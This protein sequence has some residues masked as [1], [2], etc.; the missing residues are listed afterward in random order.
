MVRFLNVA[1]YPVLNL[2]FTQR[3][4]FEVSLL[5]ELLFLT[6]LLWRTTVSYISDFTDMHLVPFLLHINF[7]DLAFPLGIEHE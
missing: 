3:E 2:F 7:I 6:F 5:F 1:I 4:P